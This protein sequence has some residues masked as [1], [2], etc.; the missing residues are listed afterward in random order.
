[1]GVPVIPNGGWID[2]RSRGFSGWYQLWVYFLA[3]VFAGVLFYLVL[4]PLLGAIPPLGMGLIGAIVGLTSGILT[5]RFVMPYCEPARIR[6]SDPG[7]EMQLYRPSIWPTQFTVPW[8]QFLG[9]PTPGR[10]GVVLLTFRHPKFR[11]QAVGIFSDAQ[12]QALLSHPA[13]PPSWTQLHVGP[14]SRSSPA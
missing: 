11:R 4:G 9:V 14:E 7:V 6:A 12:F 10:A 2:R 1:M 3:P 8:S 13:R 5:E